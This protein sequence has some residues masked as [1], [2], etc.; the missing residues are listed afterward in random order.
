MEVTQVDKKQ[1]RM[2]QA[3]GGSCG[4]AQELENQVFGGFQI[5][6]MQSHHGVEGVRKCQEGG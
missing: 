6:L 3:Q 2:S 4:K 5:C 1:V